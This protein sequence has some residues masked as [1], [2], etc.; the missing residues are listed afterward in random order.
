M[1]PDPPHALRLTFAYRGTQI[2]LVGVER[3][4]MIVPASIDEPADTTTSGYSFALLDANG[5]AIYRRPLHDPIRIDAEAF[6]PGKGRPI[7]RVPLS[8]TEGRF[9]VLVPDLPHA[10]EFR[11]SGPTDPLRAHEPAGELLHLDV[12]SLRRSVGPTPSPGT[13]PGRRP[14]G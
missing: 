10:R 13:P 5:R 7:E 2:S 11:L 14:G 4:A 1:S 8:T 9:T 3:I 6:S 12:D